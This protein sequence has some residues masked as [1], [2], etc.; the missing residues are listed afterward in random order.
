MK[1][2]E[3]IFKRFQSLNRASSMKGAWYVCAQRAMK[4]TRGTNCGKNAYRVGISERQ[5][6][7]MMML[8][9]HKIHC[10]WLGDPQLLG[11][12][13]LFLQKVDQSNLNSVL[14]L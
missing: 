2:P 9:S 4:K 1:D 8:R 14:P 5:R 10:L 7:V 6:I 13:F 3:G 12:T 11:L